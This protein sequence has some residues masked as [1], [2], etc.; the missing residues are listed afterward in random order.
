MSETAVTFCGAG[1]VVVYGWWATSLEHFTWPSRLAILVPGV[2]LLV[3]A[4]E[5]TPHRRRNRSRRTERFGAGLWAALGVLVVVWELFNYFHAGRSDYPTLSS[6][7]NGVDSTSHPIRLVMFL[8][9]VAL[10]WDL[11]KR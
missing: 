11:G 10:G 4:G 1:V 8:G 6:L 5:R 3:V 9:W 7:V 2:V